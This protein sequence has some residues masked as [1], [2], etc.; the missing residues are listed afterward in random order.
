MEA[1][2]SLRS[3]KIRKG[4]PGNINLAWIVEL[5]SLFL[6]YDA[7]RAEASHSL[8]ASSSLPLAIVLPSGL[9]A[10]LEKSLAK[11]AF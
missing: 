2:P 4:D 7:V 3:F 6:R 1:V 10:T 9:K 8:I 11:A 5:T